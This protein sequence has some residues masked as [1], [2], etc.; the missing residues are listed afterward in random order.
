M[1]T[2]TE[3]CRDVLYT[4]EVIR[5]AGVLERSC[6]LHLSLLY[7]ELG[8]AERLAQ[9]K[10]GGELAAE[11][12]FVESASV[13]L[14]QMLQ[15]LAVRTDLVTIA[16]GAAP[17]KFAS[18][19]QRVDVA[20]AKRELDALKAE[21]GTIGER[22]LASLE[23]LE[24]GASRFV[25]ALKDDPELMDRMLSGREK[26]LEELW[27]RATNFDPLQDLHGA[28]GAQA[29]TSFFEGGTI[30]EIGGGTGNGIRH[31][32][33]AL[34]KAGKLPSLTKYLFSDI[35]FLFVLGTKKIIRANWPNLA[36]DYLYLDI[37]KPFADQ[38]VPAE[39]VDL[40]YAVNA[41]HVA[42]DLV[43]SAQQ[44]KDALKP[45]GRV[46]F[47]ERVRLSPA[48]MAPRELV[49]NLSIYHRSSTERSEDRP[50]H[51]YLRPDNW[52]AILGRAGFSK[53]EVWPDHAALQSHFP[54]QYAAVVVATK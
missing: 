42:K 36:C 20:S 37:N 17:R 34:E 8:M 25:H 13:T 40:V 19:A 2:F 47:A 30:L 7:A 18:T 29:I 52:R 16:S 15:R 54:G 45:G 35:S 21:M 33:P 10:T 27:D 46:V 48:E 3:W 49:L 1:D 6:D 9:P 5:A 22:Y 26:G 14:D 11:L 53:V 31:L 38:K 12:G 24:F 4:P 23:F 50:F 39:S 44:C 28:M 43:W 41:A 51:C 32:F